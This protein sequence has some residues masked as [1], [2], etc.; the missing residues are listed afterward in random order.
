M[1][2]ISFV[3]GISL[4]FVVFLSGCINVSPEALAMANPLVKQFMEQYPNA[5][6]TVNHFTKDQSAQILENIS[7]ECGNPYI[8]AKEF[9]RISIDDPDSGLKAL[10]WIDWETRGIECAVKYGGGLNK[11]ISKPGEENQ[12]CKSHAEMKC[13]GEHVYWFDSCGH[14]EEKKEYCTSGCENGFC[15][16]KEG[17]TEHAEAKCADGHVYWYDSCNGKEDKKEYCQ[18]GCENGACKG[19]TEKTCLNEGESKPVIANP[20]PCCEG[21]TLIPP[22]AENLVGIYGYC[23]AKCGNGICNEI[24]TAYNCPSDCG[25]INCTDSDGGRNYSVKGTATVAGQSLTD[26]CNEDG[27]LT[28]KYCENNEIKA[29]SVSCPT[30]FK[31]DDAKCVEETV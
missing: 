9:Y 11:T 31:C 28:E 15:K 13:Y 17:C 4:V 10:A 8:T 23:T 26:H 2:K 30:G 14:K 25:N 19:G 3:F 24:E 6:I 29:E 22:K 12:D 18:N 20:L 5:K 16:T 7:A 21:L 1:K 27:S